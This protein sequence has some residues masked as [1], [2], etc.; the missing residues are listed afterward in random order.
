MPGEDEMEFSEGLEISII[1]WVMTLIIFWSAYALLIVFLNIGHT[2]LH[3]GPTFRWFRI[4]V[5][6]LILGIFMNVAWEFITH[7]K[8]DRYIF[9]GLE[10]AGMFWIYLCPSIYTGTKDYIS[11]LENAKDQSQNK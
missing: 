2:H 3:C 4:V 5:L 11:K 9:W 1:E 6:G 7:G 8:A 10:F